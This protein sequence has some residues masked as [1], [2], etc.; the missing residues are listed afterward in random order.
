M[1]IVL[2]VI[3]WNSLFQ[4]ILERDGADYYVRGPDDK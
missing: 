3:A 2:M 4:A 1:F